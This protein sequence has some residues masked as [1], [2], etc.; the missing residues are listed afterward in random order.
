LYPTIEGDVQALNVFSVDGRVERRSAT[1]PAAVAFALNPDGQRVAYIPIAEGL[2]DPFRLGPLIVDDAG[3]TTRVA[4]EAAAFFWSPE[5][6]GLL[7]LTGSLTEQARWN[8][9]DGK[10]TTPFERFVPTSTFIQQYFPFFGQYANSL[11]FLS[12]EGT[13]FTF[14]GTIEGRGTG[15]WVQEVATGVRARKVA[16]GVFST[17]SPL[18]GGVLER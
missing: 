9:W 10:E 1:P 15:I 2:A 7:Y 8:L 17:W 6:D 3:Q 14:A 12:P 11:S 18:L 16:D 5:G 13:S 4:E